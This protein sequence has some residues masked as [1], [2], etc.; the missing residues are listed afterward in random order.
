M[1][2]ALDKRIHA[3]ANIGTALKFLEGRK[4]E[5][6]RQKKKSVAILIFST[7][8]LGLEMLLVNYDIKCGIDS[9]SF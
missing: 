1:N 4:V 5:K 2:R 6:R 8:V 7:L 9:K 3:V